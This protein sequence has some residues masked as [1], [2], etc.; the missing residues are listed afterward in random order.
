MQSGVQTALAELQ[1][2]TTGDNSLFEHLS[3]LIASILDSKDDSVNLAYLSKLLKK[4]A[5]CDRVPDAILPYRPVPD[6]SL[7][8]RALDLFG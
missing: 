5:V 3:T 7:A 8:K 2:R 6:V 1:T 4:Q